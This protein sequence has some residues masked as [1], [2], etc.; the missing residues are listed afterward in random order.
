MALAKSG[1]GSYSRPYVVRRTPEGRRPPRFAARWAAVLWISE[2]ST[3]LGS[4]PQDRIAARQ[5]PDKEVLCFQE[6]RGMD[7]AR[8][9][10]PRLSIRNLRLARMPPMD[11]L[12]ASL[13]AFDLCNE[14]PRPLTDVVVRVV[15]AD[16]SGL[17]VGRR[18]L[19]RP[20]MLRGKAVLRQG[21]AL[22]YSL[23][24][25]NLSSECACEPQVKVLSAR[26]LSDV[27][28]P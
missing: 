15:I 23:L 11:T 27:I 21:Y 3:V 2:L 26:Q 10:E 25:R 17:A 20:L 19:A 4:A 9:R 22:R 13:L 18:P 8:N 16:K 1:G 14:G 12:P 28:S 24:F 5:G 7:S 6:G